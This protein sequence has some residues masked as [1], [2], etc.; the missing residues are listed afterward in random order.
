MTALKPIPVL[1]M[2]RELGIGG[3]ERDLT[4]LAIGLDRSR[5]EP[6]VGCF[7]PDGLRSGELR[8]RG[9][10]IVHFNVPSFASSAALRAARKMGTF[11]RERGI[12]V[13]HAFDAPTDIFAVPVARFYHTPVVI[14]SELSYRNLVVGRM[15]QYL[16]HVSA[17]AAHKIVVNSAAVGTDLRENANVPAN[18]IVLSHNGVDLRAFAPDPRIRKVFPDASLVIGA[19][20]AL[21]PEKRLD[22]LLDAFARVRVNDTD[23]RLV[24]V[25]S[26]PMLDA[27]ERQARKLQIES[28]CHFEP[29]KT[30]VA[31]WM[32]SM[33]IFVMCSESE[34][35]PNALLEAMA[36]GCCVVGSRVGGVP[37]LIAH[38]RNGLLFESRSVDDLA[39]QM[40][41]LIREPAL[42]SRL[43]KDSVRTAREEFPITAAVNRI[44]NL[45]LNLLDR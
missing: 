34:S 44:Q 45:Y 36:C 20:C 15:P 42:R 8:S 24:I 31:E 37:E 41:R 23:L 18:K 5:F 13:V 19:V 28:F 40:T 33:D 17:I 27:L 12:Q 21:R 6:Y 30:E 14:A 22:L 25:G 43:A 9:I 3:C 26:G 2:V 32:R 7:I 10:P 4:K 11:I 1:L 38:G 35:F 29:S 39:L 16:M